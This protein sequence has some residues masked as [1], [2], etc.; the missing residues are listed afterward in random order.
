MRVMYIS[1]TN[2]VLICQTTSS[3]V[4]HGAH[5]MTNWTVCSVR[6]DSL[7]DHIKKSPDHPN[8][9]CTAARWLRTHKHWH[10]LHCATEGV[11]T[12]TNWSE[13]SLCNSLCSDSRVIR[14][15]WLVCACEHTVCGRCGARRLIRALRRSN[16]HASY[17]NQQSFDQINA[18]L[19]LKF[20]LSLHACHPAG[21]VHKHSC[22]SLN[23]DP[24]NREGK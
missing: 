23:P 9:V 12:K 1:P 20:L 16:G 15:A 24:M 13:K 17:N 5:Q 11:L 18:S 22:Q 14:A 3:S 2:Q 21:H 8:S 7:M 4:W 10:I 19:P 6:P